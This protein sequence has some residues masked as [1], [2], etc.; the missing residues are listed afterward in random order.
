MR[1]RWLQKRRHGMVALLLFGCLLTTA[2]MSLAAVQAGQAAPDFRL[3][4]LSGKEISLG[5]FKGKPVVLDFW[6]SS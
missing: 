5:Q 3:P 2:G 4:L 6:D 1:T